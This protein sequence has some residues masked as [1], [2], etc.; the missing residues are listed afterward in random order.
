[1]SD[2][3]KVLLTALTGF[4]GL[5][6]AV[7]QS[8]DSN[9]HLSRAG[10]VLILCIVLSTLLAV[11]LLITEAQD[12]SR[13]DAEIAAQFERL[14][15]PF[16]LA[17]V[18]MEIEY[19]F[20]DP[21]LR[22]WLERL[23]V[24]VNRAGHDRSRQPEM[25]PEGNRITLHKDGKDIALPAGEDMTG[26]SKQAVEMVGFVRSPAMVRVSFH[27]P[28]PRALNDIAYMVDGPDPALPS[29]DPTKRDLAL[30]RRLAYES[31]VS[32]S[33]SIEQR[34]ILRHVVMTAPEPTVNNGK[35]QSM[36]ELEG[37]SIMIYAPLLARAKARITKLRLY[38][39]ESMTSFYEIPVGKGRRLADGD[40]IMIYEI[41]LAKSDLELRSFDPFRPRSD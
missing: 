36:V 23:R 29:F 4:L 21:Q 25:L 38:R 12:Q 40:G 39:D 35:L 5:L 13:R 8:R 9:G 20:S 31:G 1:M 16:V 33:V 41:P 30:G 24:M 28:G 18:E 3:I 27:K 26:L 2:A 10:R 6:A 19:P 17:A 7:T 37:G 15:K 14:Q 32:L 11:G 34:K 22:P